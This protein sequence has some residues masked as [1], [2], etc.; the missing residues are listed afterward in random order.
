L[1]TKYREEFREKRCIISFLKEQEK[2]KE[3]NKTKK[4]ASSP[5]SINPDLI[6]S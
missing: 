1:K 4:K 3:K 2:N 5:G 6:Q